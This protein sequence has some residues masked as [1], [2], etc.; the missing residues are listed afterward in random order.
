MELV[1]AGFGSLTD[2]VLHGQCAA[3]E[4]AK[5]FD[6]QREGQNDA[7]VH[8]LHY[9]HKKKSAYNEENPYTIKYTDADIFTVDTHKKQEHC[10]EADLYAI[11]P[12]THTKQS[13]SIFFMFFSR[14]RACEAFSL[15]THTK[16]YNIEDF[17]KGTACTTIK[18]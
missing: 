1:V 10:N 15:L 11:S 5:A 17:L 14:H 2:E 6:S 8:H 9:Q 13:L 3:E 18:V 16:V 7:P 4:N 12:Q